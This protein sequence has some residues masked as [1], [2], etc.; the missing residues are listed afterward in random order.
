MTNKYLLGVHKLNPLFILGLLLFFINNIPGLGGAFG[1]QLPPMLMIGLGLFL[2]IIFM[3]KAVSLNNTTFFFIFIYGFYV[4]INN[5]LQGYVSSNQLVINDFAEPIRVL[6]LL[7][8]FSLGASCYSLVKKRDLELFLN[9]YLIISLLLLLGWIFGWIFSLGIFDFYI[10]RGGRYSGLLASVNYVWVSS[11]LSVGIVVLYYNNTD[12]NFKYLLTLLLIIFVS[13]VSIIL[14]GGRASIL[15][16]LLASIILVLFSGKK[17]RRLSYSI[18]SVIVVS[19]LLLMAHFQEGSFFPQF[20]RT[21][22]RMGELIIAIQYVDLTQV[23]AF[24]A[25]VNMWQRAWGHINERFLFGHGSSKAGI[26]VIDNTYLMSLYR[27]GLIGLLLELM[28]YFSFLIL[29]IKKAFKNNMYLLPIAFV[30]AYFISGITS[31][32]FYELKTP[33]ILTFLMGWFTAVEPKFEQNF[34]KTFET[35]KKS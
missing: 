15:G 19:L 34:K 13:L 10:T 17:A 22:S 8:F 31:S 12:V 3:P 23:A 20:E 26:R 32:P 33:Y 30:L 35:F 9:I 4:I 14:S 24:E 2:L 7:T 25:R 18:L 29:A 6:G 11:V 1:Q 21:V 5:L 28:I 16:F 27:Y